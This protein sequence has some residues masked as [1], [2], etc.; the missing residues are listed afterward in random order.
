MLLPFLYTLRAHKIP[1]GTQ[2]WLALMEA[3]CKDT[4]NSSLTDFYYIAR[5]ILVKSEALFD[6][7]DQAFLVCFKGKEDD[8]N[9]KKE[10]LEWL[11][12]NVDPLQRPKMPFDIPPLALEELRRRFLER[13]K[14]QNDEHHG[15]SHW[16]GTGGTSPLGHSGAHPSGI[17][18][19]GAGGGRSAVQVAEERRFANYRYDRVLDIRQLQVALKRLRKLEQTGPKEELQ[20]EETIDKTAKNG[21]EIDLI[22]DSPHKNISELLLLMDTGGSMD[23]YAELVETL[24]SAAHASKHFKTFRHFYFHNCIYSRVYTDMVHGKYVALEELFRNHGKNFN[25]VLVGDACMSPYELVYAGGS[26]NYWENPLTPGIDWFQRFKQHYPRSIWLNPQEPRTWN[27]P[28][29][30]SIGKVFRM[31][32]LTVEGITEAIDHLRGIF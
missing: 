16:I 9:L 5:S 27:H 7:F 22:F 2:E 1:V 24:F 3:L 6:A 8:F 26:I 28:T 15:G 31:F 11:D 29:I 18:I 32:P 4:A 13:L 21:G 10:L 30:A 12:R 14:E 25:V 17:R 20:L 19:G 23:P